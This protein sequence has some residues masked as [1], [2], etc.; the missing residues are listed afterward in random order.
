[1][2][3]YGEDFLQLLV[4]VE[5]NLIFSIAVEPVD[6]SKQAQDKDLSPESG[7]C[8][9]PFLHRTAHLT[10]L[11]VGPFDGARPRAQQETRPGSPSRVHVISVQGRVA[12]SAALQCQEL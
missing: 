7:Q 3:S 1:M 10:W 6:A 5:M 8:M 12:L 4:A 11:Q 9:C 2:V